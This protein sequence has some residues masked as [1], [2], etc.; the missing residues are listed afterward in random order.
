MGFAQSRSSESSRITLISDW[1]TGGLLGVGVFF[2][3][4][5]YLITDLLVSEYRRN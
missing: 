4:S 2:V 3:L 1:A 5:G